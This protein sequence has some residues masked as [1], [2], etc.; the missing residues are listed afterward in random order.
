MSPCI[1]L[2]TFSIAAAMTASIFSVHLNCIS[3]ASTI[4]QIESA[5][6]A[7]VAASMEI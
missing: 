1:E 6:A 4:S 2:H 7:R 5:A 3:A